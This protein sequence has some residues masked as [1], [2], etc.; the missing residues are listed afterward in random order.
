M[1]LSPI[2]RNQL[3][4][5]GLGTMLALMLH[6]AFICLLLAAQPDPDGYA[7]RWLAAGASTRAAPDAPSRTWA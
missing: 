6:A 3:L 4:A 7:A 1:D 5:T 2:L